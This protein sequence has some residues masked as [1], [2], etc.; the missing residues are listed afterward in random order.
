MVRAWLDQNLV[1]PFNTHKQ[2]N[3]DD[4]QC[5]SAVATLVPILNQHHLACFKAASRPESGA[6]LNCVPNNRVS[7][8]IDNDT[9]RIGVSLCVGLTI[10]IPHR[11]KCGTTVDAFGT[12]PLSCR[13]SA[14]RIRRRKATRWN[15]S[16]PLLTWPLY[17]SGRYVR[18]HACIFEPNTSR[19]RSASSRRD[20][21]RHCEIDDPIFLKIW[22]ADWP[23][24]F[25]INARAISCS[26][27]GYSQRERL[28][29]FA[30]VP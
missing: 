22:V 15:N 16:V 30:V 1:L 9:L 21:R 7:T 24:D 27:V 4:I 26:R 13:F 6:W 12:H 3:L 28:Q 25:R 14:G 17:H 11:S 8:F 20:V 19:A 5:S 29:H 18:Q 23:C 2:R 10:C